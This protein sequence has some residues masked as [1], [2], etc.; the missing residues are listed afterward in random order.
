[1]RALFVTLSLLTMLGCSKQPS[2]Y[3]RLCHIYET[4]L[5]KPKTSENAVYLAEEV[6]RQ[7]PDVYADFGLIANADY[8]KRYDL[9]RAL[10]R[11]KAHQDDWRCEAVRTYYEL[12]M[13]DGVGA[14]PQ[15]PSAP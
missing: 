11:D 7:L 12:P 3:D 5:T 8:S 10:A 13:Q 4:Y 14:V 15:S 6:E 9:F 1:M 2:S